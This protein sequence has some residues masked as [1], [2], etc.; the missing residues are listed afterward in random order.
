MKTLVT[1]G[2]G[3]IGSNVVRLLLEKGHDV[4][5][6]D[7][8]SSGYRGN[9][10]PFPQVRFYEG[11]I[12]DPDTVA[13]AT[14]GVEVVF[15]LA[16][17]VGNTR[18]IEHPIKDSEVNALG[19]LRILE[20]ARHGGVRKVVFSSSA[21]IFGE[22]KTLPIMEDHPV[23]PDS[24]Y[25]ASK[26][27]AE[28]LCLAYAKLYPMEC[29]C[30]RY[31]NVYGPNQ[32]YDAYGNVIPIFAHRMIHGEPV[33]IFGDGEQTRDF[34]NV[35]DVARANYQAAM[36]RGVSGAFNVA[37]GT[38]ITIN[39]LVEL[40]RE[41]SG[42]QPRVEYGPPRRGDVRHS[43]ANISAARAAFGYEPV[44]GLKEGLAEYMDWAKTEM[45]REGE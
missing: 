22:L 31:F 10:D 36:A 11:D 37:S 25:G 19:T 39:H 7:D 17:S 4:T 8:L 18:S 13:Q 43:L 26:L 2:A 27:A 14:A 41:A 16:A 24:P 5:V 6:L 23:E 42:L 9:L 1:G 15:H 21:G 40:M 30:L 32:R 29:V 3:F 38:R 12:R 45:V 28:K 34:V 44:V 20:A 33:V 35:H